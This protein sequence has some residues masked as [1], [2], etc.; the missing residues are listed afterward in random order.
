MDIAMKSVLQRLSAQLVG[1]A[2]EYGR[3][4]GE[5]TIIDLPLTRQELAELI[6]V[7]RETATRELSKLSRAGAVRLEGKKIYITDWSML[8]RWAK[9]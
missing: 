3:E 5:E 6:G 8:E 1:L 7:T 2:E 9:V 4:V